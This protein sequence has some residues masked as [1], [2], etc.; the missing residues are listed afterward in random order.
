M[1]RFVL[2]GLTLCLKCRK[3]ASENVRYQSLFFPEMRGKVLTKE[4]F[5]SQQGPVATQHVH[6]TD[7]LYATSSA[8]IEIHYTVTDQLYQG[9]SQKA[10]RAHVE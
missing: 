6:H 7:Q 5:T 1:Q 2:K 4:P 9:F 3:I 8:A 10:K